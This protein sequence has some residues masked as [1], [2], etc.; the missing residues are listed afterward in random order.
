MT[1]I[2]LELPYFADSSAIFSKIADRSWPI[3]LDS[4]NRFKGHH[5]DLLAADPI[6]KLIFDPDN[7]AQH[8]SDM[9]V[10]SSLNAC[11]DE[12]EG[13]LA[14]YQ[15]QQPMGP[16]WLGF[17]SYDL[18]SQLEPITK[19]PKREYLP[20]VAI[21]YYG[22]VVVTHH[23]LQKTVIYGLASHAQQ[24]YAIQAL[25]QSNHPTTETTRSAFQLR[26]KFKAI[27]P[28]SEYQ[29][30]FDAVKKY[31]RQGD[32]YQVNLTQEFTARCDGDPAQA[33]IALRE[34]HPSPMS[35]Y[36][37]TGE[38]S[39]LSLSPERFIQCNN[40]QITTQP[41]KGTRPRSDNQDLDNTLKTALKSSLKDRAEN[42]MI[43]DLLR[44][45]LGRICETGSVTTTKLFDVES[46]PNVHHLVSTIEGRL[47]NNT[48]LRDIIKAVFP[49]GSITGAPKF[50]AMEIIEELEPHRRSI[51]CGSFIYLCGNGDLDS[52]IAIRTLLVK[53]NQIHCWGGGGI[54]A[55][56]QCDNEYQET[57]DKVGKLMAILENQFKA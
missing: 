22:W 13:T 14:D 10:A 56:S 6:K 33:Y 29:Q 32:C 54:V 16:G 55:D 47:K 44:N 18:F 34:A 19:R 25:L 52:N 12:L 4:G 5:T 20:N 21:G 41:I 50:R 45:D 40:R 38:F 24:A 36:F 46:F 11:F 30:Q 49:G 43:V 23:H 53:N 9:T 35:A 31:I 15:H 1:V 26:S 42:V 48:K 2:T 28:R 51:Y 8:H 7:T 37:S 3:W 17:L 39:I 27:T 57:L